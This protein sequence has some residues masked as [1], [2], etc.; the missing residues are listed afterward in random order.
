MKIPRDL[1]GEELVKLLKIYGYQPVRQSGSHIRMTTQTNGEHHVVIPNHSPLK[2]GLLS[3]ILTD[4]AD[5][6][7]KTKEEI[8]R[9]LF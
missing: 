5:H 1:S 7:G 4:I 8:V 2:I 3:S 6:L 9:D